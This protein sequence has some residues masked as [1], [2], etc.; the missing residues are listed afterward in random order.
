[1]VRKRRLQ[2]LGRVSR[3]WMKIAYRNSSFL[4]GSHKFDLHKAHVCGGWTGSLMISAGKLGVTEW[5]QLANDQERTE[6]RTITHMLPSPTI[7]PAVSCE[8]CERNFKS[9]AGLSRHKCTAARQLP[10][11]EQPGAR[12]CEKCLRWFKSPGGLAVH[13][14]HVADSSSSPPSKPPSRVPVSSLNFCSFHCGTCHRC[15]KSGSGFCRH[16][17]QRGMRRPT[18]RDS[19]QHLCPTCPQKFR[20]PG[21][22][23]RH[24][25]T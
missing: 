12:Q 1:M 19:F 15:F 2:W 4:D 18:E 9:K 7:I 5:Y 23:K 20:R 13:K 25:C 17:C 16:N 8:V 11:Q 3:I 24:K 10:I 14:C 22:L 21:D 6:W